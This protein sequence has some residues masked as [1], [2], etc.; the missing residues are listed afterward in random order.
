MPAE[1]LDHQ[2]G[3]PVGDGVEAELRGAEALPD[4]DV[5]EIGGDATQDADADDVLAEAGEDARP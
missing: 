2:F 3:Y 4:D 1:A 5:V